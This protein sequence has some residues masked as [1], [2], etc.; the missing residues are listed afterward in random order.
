MDQAFMLIVRAAPPRPPTDDE[1]SQMKLTRAQAVD[2]LARLRTRQDLTLRRTGQGAYRV[3]LRAEGTSHA[4]FGDLPLLQAADD[5]EADKRAHV[6]RVVTDF[7]RAFF[8][9]TLKGSKPPLPD[10][11]ATGGIVERVE[12]FPPA[13]LPNR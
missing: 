8:D 1:L 13:T 12:E 4:D 3:T 7:T 9:K 6:L 10:P 2:L 11:S 5:R